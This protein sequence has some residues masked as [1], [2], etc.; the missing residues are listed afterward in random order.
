MEKDTVQNLNEDGEEIKILKGID[1]D[2]IQRTEDFAVGFNPEMHEFIIYN[3]KENKVETRGTAIGFMLEGTLDRRGKITEGD[4]RDDIEL[5]RNIK[6][7]TNNKIDIVKLKKDANK[8]IKKYWSTP[9]MKEVSAKIDK[10]NKQ[11][12][13][14]YAK[15]S[16]EREKN[17]KDLADSFVKLADTVKPEMTKEK[18]SNAKDN[19][20]IGR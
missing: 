1:E 4:A 9:E 17:M 11:L 20:G 8:A 2:T 19:H 5:S 14:I 7:A 15:E 3:E 18:E 10:I 13:R 16:L 6:E 12:D